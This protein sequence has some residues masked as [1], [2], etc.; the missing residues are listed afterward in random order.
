MEREIARLSYQPGGVMGYLY[1]GCPVL[2]HAAFLVERLHIVHDSV[3]G[4][5]Q[6]MDTS[7]GRALKAHMLVGG[8]VSFGAEGTG[9]TDGNGVVQD[10]FHL[11]AF[12][13]SSHALL[14]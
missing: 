4:T 6:F 3:Q 7:D 2:D 9:R 12:V 5:L 11:V 8:Q 14:L 10:D 1:K 13:A